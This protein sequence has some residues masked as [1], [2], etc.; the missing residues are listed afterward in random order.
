MRAQARFPALIRGYGAEV[1]YFH[2]TR[3]AVTGRRRAM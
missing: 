3:R 2:E 1:S